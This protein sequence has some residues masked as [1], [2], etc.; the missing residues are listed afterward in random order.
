MVYQHPFSAVRCSNLNFTEVEKSDWRNYKE[1]QAIQ[2]NQHVRGLKRGSIWSVNSAQANSIR[3]ENDEGK[4]A[5]PPRKSLLPGGGRS[6]I[7]PLIGL[8]KFMDGVRQLNNF[9]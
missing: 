7:E 9:T 3:L 6:S 5:L 8:L 4:T 1:G 2:F